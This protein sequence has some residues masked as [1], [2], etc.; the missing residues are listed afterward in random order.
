MKIL[1]VGDFMQGSGLTNYIID[2]YELF[3]KQNVIVDFASYSG[4]NTMDEYLEKNDYNIFK[5]FPITK[6]PFIH[7]KDWYVFFKDNKNT[8]D[9]IH[10]NY[11]ASWNFF[12]VCLCRNMTNSK[13]IIHSHNNYFSKVP[14]NIFEKKILTIVNDFGRKIFNKNADVKL[15]ASKDAGD[16]MFGEKNPYIFVQ[17]GIDLNKY[18]FNINSR[19]IMRESL[20]IKK[21]DIVLGF[22]GRL[23]DRKNPE[24]CI[25]LLS[26][27]SKKEKNY[28]LVFLGE[29]PLKDELY[30][31]AL[32]LNLENDC[33]LIGNVHNVNEWYSAMDIFLFPSV[34][35]G[36]G[37]VLLEAQINGL[38]C[39]ASK[40]LPDEAKLT[41][42]VVNIDLELIDTCIDYID[43][44]KSNL[45]LRVEKSKINSKIIDEAG[46]SICATSK[47]LYK[48]E[49]KTLKNY[50]IRRNKWIL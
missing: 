43:C 15:A 29:G 14:K 39:L 4:S 45:D 5:I 23:E 24:F 11:S 35:E 25:N 47:K 46:F 10:F 48:L 26:K 38:Y 40:N 20:Q 6:N 18:I 32:K 31:C 34:T 9:L 36:F 41:E 19:K 28:K 2:T 13:I 7:I 33:Y 42:S 21:D 16:W 37:Y 30:K 12:A 3:N 1:V 27:L 50:S 44:F 49:K 8:Y 22:V 17:N